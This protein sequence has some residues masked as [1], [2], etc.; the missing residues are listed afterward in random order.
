MTEQ[1]HNFVD[2]LREICHQ[3]RDFIQQQQETMKFQQQMIQQ[4]QQAASTAKFN[5]PQHTMSH[6]SAKKTESQILSLNRSLA[7]VRQRLSQHHEWFLEIKK[8]ITNTREE[9]AIFSKVN[10]DECQAETMNE[11]M[12]E[13]VSQ[14]PIHTDEEA[15]KI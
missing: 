14:E 4:L 7:C 12:S 1:Q 13:S 15:P 2:E 10:L 11:S 3:Q 6:S 9:D 5:Q 8:Q